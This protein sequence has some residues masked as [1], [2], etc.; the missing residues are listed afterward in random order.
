M[1]HRQPEILGP[2]SHSKLQFQSISIS[3][4]GDWHVKSQILDSSM[5]IVDYLD[6]ITK[7][8]EFTRIYLETGCSKSQNPQFKDSWLTDCVRQF[9][10]K[11]GIVLL[12]I[13][14]NLDLL[15]VYSRLILNLLELPTLEQCIQISVCLEMFG[16]CLKTDIWCMFN[17]YLKSED[18]QVIRNLYIPWKHLRYNY[19]Q[20]PLENLSKLQQHYILDRYANIYLTKVQAVLESID[21]YYSSICSGVYINS[22][23]VFGILLYKSFTQLMCVFADIQILAQVL[24]ATNHSVLYLGNYHAIELTK[25]LIDLGATVDC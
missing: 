16:T 20:S 7:K 12:E 4:F 19:C 3:I 25:T 8:L 18:S 15:E 10:G 22:I 6:S 21:M 2:V 9:S 14:D 13:Y 5:S 23:E 11:P 1:Q 24:V 17:Y